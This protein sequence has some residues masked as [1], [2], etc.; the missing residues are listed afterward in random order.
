MLHQVAGAQD[1]KNR[2]E[3]RSKRV[4]MIVKVDNEV[5]SDD[6]LMREQ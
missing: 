4:S 3:L 2:K 1:R 6:E 5:A